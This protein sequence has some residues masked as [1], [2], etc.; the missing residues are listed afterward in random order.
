MN[1][2]APAMGSVRVAIVGVGNCASSLVQGVEYYRDADPSQ[3]VP[4]LMHVDFGGYHV[5]DVEF[6]AA[7]DV[8]AKKVG[9]DLAEAIVAS[10]NNTIKLCDVPP[11]NVTVQ[12]G[13]THDGLGKYYREMVEESDEP[14]VDVAAALREARVDV[15][16]SYLPV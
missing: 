6:V 15:L 5:R 8:D 1:K 2:E 10:E 7:F 9:R 16:V 12:R 11:T 14:A 4:G 3:R 13:H